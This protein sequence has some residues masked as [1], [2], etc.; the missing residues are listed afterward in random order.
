MVYQLAMEAA[1][2][3]ITD[4]VCKR[5]ELYLA[6]SKEMDELC[7]VIKTAKHILNNEKKG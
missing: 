5:P 6:F 4:N 7:D 1:L 3:L 2:Q